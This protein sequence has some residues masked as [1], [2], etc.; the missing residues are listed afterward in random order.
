MNGQPTDQLSHAAVLN[1]LRQLNGPVT[2]HVLT[3]NVEKQPISE[4][5]NRSFD[6]DSSKGTL[7][8][9]Q[10]LLSSTTA[11]SRMSQLSLQSSEIDNR[12]PPQYADA[13][14]PEHHASLR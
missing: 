3:P 13:T 5:N 12:Y 7:P 14:S 10:P 6:N 2:L 11:A 4:A 9:S 1:L 8:I